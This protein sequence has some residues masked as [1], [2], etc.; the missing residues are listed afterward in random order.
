[1]KNAPPPPHFSLSKY[2]SRKDTQTSEILKCKWCIRKNNTILEFFS[3]FSLLK[4]CTCIIKA[5]FFAFG[6]FYW[7]R[8]VFKPKLEIQSLK[9]VERKKLNVD[10]W[11]DLLCININL[12][13]K[14]PYVVFKW[15]TVI[16]NIL[17]GLILLKYSPILSTQFI[18]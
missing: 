14:Q 18:F 17:T 16:Y 15:L 4:E 6:F 5:D 11:N 10:Y 1:M 3:V 13:K 8:A 2:S 7:K 12:H 9:F